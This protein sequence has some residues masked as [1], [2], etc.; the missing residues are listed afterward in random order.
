VIFF[1]L[2]FHFK[3]QKDFYNTLISTSS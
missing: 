2:D 1:K 3:A